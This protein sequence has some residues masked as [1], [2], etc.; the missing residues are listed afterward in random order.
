MKKIILFLA[1]LSLGVSKAQVVG[2]YLPL[3][4]SKSAT[5]GGLRVNGTTLT[6]SLGIG[7]LPS[8][9]LSAFQMVK[10][11]G[12]VNI[13]EAVAGFPAI[14]FDTPISTSNYA[15]RGN[16]SNTSINATQR[17]Q[18]NINNTT[19][20]VWT[21]TGLRVGSSSDPSAVL[22]VTGD[23]KVS[24]TFSL[25]SA[26]LTGGNT[27]T[28]AV[29]SDAVFPINLNHIASSPA[30]ATEY[31]L[32]NNAFLYAG[33]VSGSITIPYNCTLVAWNISVVNTGGNGSAGS[34]TVSISGTTNYT[35]ST[36]INYTTVT[37]AF[38]ASGLSQNFSAGDVFNIKILTP[39]WAT[40]PLATFHGVTLWFVRRS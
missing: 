34:S 37:Q 19:K 18:H 11:T 30:D 1:L 5:M 29:L 38:S 36:A 15:F 2:G 26:N 27:G 7:V 14:W 35:M 6:S 12:S 33:A 39:T 20:G 4:S 9:S 21:S 13:G 17:Q 23:A 32:G 31:Y 40:N 25:G 22:D 10:G 28:V 3:N 16:A 8:S 24:S